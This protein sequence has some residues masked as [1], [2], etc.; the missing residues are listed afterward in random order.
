MAALCSSLWFKGAVF[1][2]AGS[3]NV[4]APDLVRYGLVLLGWSAFC[5]LIWAEVAYQP[6]LFITKHCGAV[7]L[8]IQ[9]VAIL[10]VLGVFGPYYIQM[11][12]SFSAGLSRYGPLPQAT[13]ETYNRSILGQ[14][15]SKESSEDGK[16]EGIPKYFGFA[17]SKDVERVITER[18]A[19]G[20]P[21]SGNYLRGVL[22]NCGRDARSVLLGALEDPNACDVL[23]IRAKWGDR[24]VKEPLEHIYQEKLTAFIQ[25]EPEPAPHYPWSL[26]EL[27]ELA[28]TLAR[29][30]D[31][32]KAQE[33]FSY[34]MEQ[35]VEKA[36]N[37]G[38]GPDLGDP[39]YT[40]RIIQPFWESLGELPPAATGTLIK[41][42]LR[43]TGFVDLSA[44]RDRA[45]TFLA[46]LL[47]DGDRELAEEVIVALDGLPSTS[48]LSDAL[49]RESEQQRIFRLTRHRDKNAPHCLEAIFAHLTAESI[50]L[51][52]EHLDSDNDQLRAF[53]VWRLTSLGYQWSHEQL[54]ELFK[55]TFWK[56]RLNVLFTLDAD[57]LA[58]ALDDENAVV[59][60]IARILR[61]AK[62]F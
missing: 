60:L 24:T 13:Q 9:W 40:D 37:L 53:I 55:D 39:R 23:V 26:G 31:G 44:D 17:A 2:N 54:R 19:A 43:Q 35:V 62:P 15:L 3:L 18:R 10:M 29:I 16:D 47:A 14:G 61:E 57:V 11:E 38:T 49:V 34:L 28:G 27:L 41:S 20:R 45:I 56:V 46:D 42:Y 5:V 59:R 52:L 1:W 12:R 30:S 32:P 33:R 4:S 58:N 51:L 6:D 7:V 21:I 22:R 50:P 36:R 25:S 8:M 48:E